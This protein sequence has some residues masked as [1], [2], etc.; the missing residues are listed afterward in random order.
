M[1][2]AER[3]CDWLFGV[4]L[5]T[6]LRY[7]DVSWGVSFAVLFIAMVWQLKSYVDGYRFGFG[8]D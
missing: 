7:N 4:F 5:I 6:F 3:I 1:T 8:G 2:W